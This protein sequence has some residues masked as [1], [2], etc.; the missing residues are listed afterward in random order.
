MAL[1]VILRTTERYTAPGIVAGMSGG[2]TSHEA[3]AMAMNREQRRYLQKQG[4]IDAEG[5][6][7]ATP[8]DTRPQPKG[9]SVGLRQY[10]SE[11][12]TELRRVQWP[13]KNEVINY[14]MVVIVT[15]IIMTAF[16]AGADLLFGRGVIKLLE[17]GQ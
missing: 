10:T 17:L 4:Q 1:Q 14:T 9:E 3:S 2:E 16:I 7:V 12:K 8:R 5:N 15:L 11:V 13:T 6:P